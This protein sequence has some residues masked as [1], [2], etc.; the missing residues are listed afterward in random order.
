MC[1]FNSL[2]YRMYIRRKKNINIKILSS[3]III[4]IKQKKYFN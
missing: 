2:Y 3:M 1:T 4:K